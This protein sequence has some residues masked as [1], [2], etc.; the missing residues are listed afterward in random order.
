MESSPARR[1]AT[2]RGGARRGGAGAF[3]CTL[4]VAL[5][6]GFSLRC[7]G[8]GG[9]AAEDVPSFT[10]FLVA[11]SHIQVVGT[12]LRRFSRAVCSAEFLHNELS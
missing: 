3:L 12:M 1:G 9:A 10:T 11:S 8:G 7:G 4:S 6:I 5:L 2:E